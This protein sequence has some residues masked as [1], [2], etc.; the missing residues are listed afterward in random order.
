MVDRVMTLVTNRDSEDSR[1]RECWRPLVGMSTMEDTY[2]VQG[3]CSALST[4]AVGHEEYMECA[5]S[6]STTL[7]SID[8]KSMASDMTTRT[9]DASSDTEE[10][11]VFTPRYSSW[12]FSLYQ[13]KHEEDTSNFSFS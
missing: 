1:P 7:H 4:A 13:E 11:M 10:V 9:M 5:T 8:M 12:W 6:D 3:V 2:E